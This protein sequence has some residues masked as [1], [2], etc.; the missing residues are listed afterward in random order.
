MQL[1]LHSLKVS[2]EQFDQI[3]QANPEWQFEQTAD[4]ELIIVPPT[5]GTSGR[6]NLN[7]AGHSRLG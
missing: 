6:K 5:G 3:A 1:T 2:D 4:G 7:L